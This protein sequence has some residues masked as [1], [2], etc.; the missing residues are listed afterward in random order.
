VATV[1]ERVSR[2]EERVNKMDTDL[3]E[4]FIEFR[5]FVIETIT[6]A[7]GRLGARFDGVAVKLAELDSRLGGKLDMLLSRVPRRPR[8]SRR[9]RVRRRH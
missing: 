9:H 5:A 8:A 1:E 6:G 3:K 2:L 4:H 7:E